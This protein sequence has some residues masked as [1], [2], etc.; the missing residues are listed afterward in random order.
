[1]SVAQQVVLASKS[2]VRKTLLESLSLPFTVQPSFVDESKIIA[3]DPSLVALKRAYEKARSVSKGSKLSLVIGSDQVLSFKGQIFSK[4]KSEKEAFS[5]LEKFQGDEHV[6]HSAVCLCF[7]GDKGSEGFEL[8]SWVSKASM[9]MKPLKESEIKA[10]VLTG[11][12]QG[13]V[14]GYKIEGKG[15]ELFYPQEEGFDETIIMGLPLE[16]LVK[17]LE[18]FGCDLRKEKKLPFELKI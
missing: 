10:Y 14:G 7:S 13:C 16:K 8:S 15:K 18:K 5:H 12:W 2:S 17:E 1:M 3:K 4:P 9:R 11:E 6:L